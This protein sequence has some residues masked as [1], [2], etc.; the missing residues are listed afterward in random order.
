MRRAAVLAALAAASILA[1]CV[2]ET[3]PATKVRATQ[4][5]LNAFGHTNNGP[6]YWLVGVRHDSEGC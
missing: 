3:S 6:A 2:G 1:G 5:Q 4:A